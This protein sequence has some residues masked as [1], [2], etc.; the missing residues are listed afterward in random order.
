MFLDGMALLVRLEIHNESLSPR[1]RSFGQGYWHMCHGETIEDKFILN[2]DTRWNPISASSR[3][4]TRDLCVEAI[5]KF[6]QPTDALMNC[7]IHLK[8][9]RYIDWIREA[10]FPKQK[11]S[12]TRSF[13][14][15]FHGLMHR[16]FVFVSIPELC[17][18]L[19]TISRFFVSLRTR[20]RLLP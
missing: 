12:S 15:E 16:F 20:S 4:Q 11:N 8:A 14:T 1:S 2:D 7:P 3:Q 9:S 13:D 18:C 10:S 17:C 6:I 19:L 5:S